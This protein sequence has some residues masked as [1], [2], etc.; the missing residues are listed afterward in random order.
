MILQLE[1]TGTPRIT[2]RPS[3]CSTNIANQLH[4]RP[5]NLKDHHSCREA[6]E[7]EE[8]VEAKDKD[9][10]DDYDKK[11]W[12]DKKCYKCDKEGHPAL[13]CPK[14]DKKDKD[15][16]ETTSCMQVHKFSQECEETH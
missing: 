12:A 5:S 9:A 10:N 6:V 15:D 14:K 3:I 4:P 1:T 8:K 13:H 7:E 16:N 11:Y 2:N